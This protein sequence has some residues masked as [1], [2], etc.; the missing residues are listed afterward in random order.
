[1]ATRQLPDDYPVSLSY[2]RTKLGI[3][4][5]GDR[6]SIA[7]VTKLIEQRGFPKPLPGMST[8]QAKLIDGVTTKSR[9]L[10]VAVDQWFDDYLPREVAASVEEARR[11]KAGAEMDERAK[12]LHL[13]D[14]RGFRPAYHALPED[15]RQRIDAIMKWR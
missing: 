9:W 10:R 6:R 15:E 7:Y 5:F 11:V 8:R 4:H 3:L 1:M 2:V 14:R 13:R 12:Y